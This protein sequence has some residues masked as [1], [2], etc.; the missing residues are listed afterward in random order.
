MG[1]IKLKR[2]FV[3]VTLLIVALFLTIP[4]T[5]FSFV[6]NPILYI[7]RFKWQSGFNALGD[8]FKRLAISV[9]QFGNASCATLF[10]ICLIKKG[11]YAF[12]NIDDTVSYILGRNY[13]RGTL[14]ILGRIIV[15]ILNVIDKDHVIKA[16]NDK[17]ESDQEA[18]LRIQNNE[19]FK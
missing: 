10:D 6:L 5:L 12:G 4:L 8:Y 3:G 7:V 13:Y 9:D 15:F 19:Y 1:K 18:L 11:G 2:F 16:V 17:V 14:S